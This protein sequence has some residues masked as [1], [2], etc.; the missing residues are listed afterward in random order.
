[1]FINGYSSC[2]VRYVRVQRSGRNGNCCGNRYSHDYRIVPPYYRNVSRL[3]YG[4]D[5]FANIVNAPA[6]TNCNTKTRVHSCI[7][8]RYEHFGR[9]AHI[10]TSTSPHS[11]LV[12]TVEFARYHAR[13]VFCQ[14]CHVFLL[15]IKRA[16]MVFW[17][18]MHAAKYLSA[19]A[20][21]A[22][23]RRL[24]LTLVEIA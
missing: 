8:P 19:L 10:C 24:L 18:P 21:G 1:M 5:G 4:V 23:E 11:A 7:E 14:F 13:I 20:L 15:E 17:R 16:S 12:C 2:R 9:D 3:Q 22:S 6:Q